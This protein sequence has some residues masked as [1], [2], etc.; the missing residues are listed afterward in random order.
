MKHKDCQAENYIEKN[1][2]ILFYVCVEYL[3]PVTDHILLQKHWFGSC[4]MARN[5]FC[6]DNRWRIG[7]ES[8][9]WAGL[10]GCDQGKPLPSFQSG[11]PV[12]V[13]NKDTYSFWFFILAVNLATLE[14]IV[15]VQWYI[16]K[17]CISEMFAGLLWFCFHW[18]LCSHKTCQICFLHIHAG[19]LVERKDFVWS[20]E[21]NLDTWMAAAVCLVASACCGIVFVI[22]HV[23]RMCVCVCVLV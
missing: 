16:H 5:A 19:K 6:A 11:R 23:W 1:L 4:L 15:M 3:W 18:L 17:S 9:D 22:G 8:Q 2:F 13:E 21:M 12:K 14:I 20:R 10:G 7:Y